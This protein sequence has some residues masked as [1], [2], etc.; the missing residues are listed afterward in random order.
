VVIRS[1]NAIRVTV[2]PAKPQRTHL[3]GVMKNK[4]GCNATLLNEDGTEQELEFC[5]SD[6]L[7]AGSEVILVGKRGKKGGVPEV[8]GTSTPQVISDRLQRLEEKM[9]E[10]DA[11]M[12]E[13]LAR[14]QEKVNEKRLERME[15]VKDKVPPAGQ[16]KINGNISKAGGKPDKED[17]GG[18][19]PDDKGGGKPDDKGGGKPDTGGSSGGGSSSGGGKPD[20]GGGGS[21]GGGGKPDKG[22]GGGSS[23]GGKGGGKK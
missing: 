17:K 15:K 9:A 21:S 22:G 11:R 16:D 3:R 12:A 5:G 13:K 4:D 6:D 14:M 8:T 23:G 19:P 7:G 20:T 18:G 10:K 2:V 1:V